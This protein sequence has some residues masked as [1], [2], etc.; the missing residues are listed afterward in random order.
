[1]MWVPI[2]KGVV[3]TQEKAVD[4]E[5]IEV[6]E[7]EAIFVVDLLIEGMKNKIIIQFYF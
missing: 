4:V 2:M 1:M 3:K 7:D 6:E 5:D